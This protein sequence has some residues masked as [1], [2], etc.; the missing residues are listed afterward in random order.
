MIVQAGIMYGIEGM[1]E[2]SCNNNND[3]ENKINEYCYC[4]N[5]RNKRI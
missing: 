1:N 4:N 5:D 2:Y 3:D